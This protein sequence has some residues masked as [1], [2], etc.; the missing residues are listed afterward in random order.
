MFIAQG[1]SQCCEWVSEN[2]E[3]RCNEMWA[4]GAEAG[5]NI[6]SHCPATCGGCE[7]F[8]CSDTIGTFILEEEGNDHDH[9]T[10]DCCWLDSLSDEM[11]KAVCSE[12]HI[13]R[14]CQETCG[15]CSDDNGMRDEEEME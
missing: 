13:Q 6:K 15:F 4:R 1:E 9:V 14:T 7:E 2:P 11:K 10:K 8:G 5:L 3:E 12:H